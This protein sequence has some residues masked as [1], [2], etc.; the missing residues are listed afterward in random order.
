MDETK[1][2][3]EHSSAANQNRRLVTLIRKRLHERGQS[4]RWLCDEMRITQIYWRAIANGSRPIMGLPKEKLVVI[5]EL[6]E[7]P[8][9]QVYALG[10]EFSAE[11][12]LVTKD[13]DRQLMA[14][15]EKMTVDPEWM[16]LAPAADDWAT[17][18][19]AVRI[20]LAALYERIS[21]QELLTGAVAE[22]PA[23]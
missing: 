23:G 16:H 18:P 2:D 8:L 15:W 3:D 17:T 5:A 20:A 11:D 9:V 22:R 6:L 19:R 12:F 21:G 14:T 7:L 4:D 10:G 13:L 1:P